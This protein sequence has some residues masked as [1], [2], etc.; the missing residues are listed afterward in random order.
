MSV[1]GAPEANPRS[2]VRDFLAAPTPEITVVEALGSDPLARMRQEVQTGLSDPDRPWVPATYLY[3]HAGSELY[4]EITRNPE[5]YLT[6][7]EVGLLSRIAPS[8]PTRVGASQLVELGSGASAKTRIVLDAFHAGSLPLTYI[9]IDVSHEM[10][11]QVAAQLV[12]AYDGMRVLGV[13]AEFDEA[14][15]ILP[16]SEGRLFMFFGGTLGNFSPAQQEVFFERLR[17][18]MAP[19][20]HLLLGFDVRPH[21]GKPAAVI[22]AAYDDAQ[23]LMARFNT[24]LLVR[25]NRELAADFRLD[26]WEHRAVYNAAEHQIELILESMANQ[27]VHV[28]DVPIRFKA[29][30][31]ILT[32][33]SRK[34]DPGELLDWLAERGFIR[35][36]F[37]M[38]DEEYYGMLLLRRA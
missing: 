12:E 22:Q 2:A 19:G 7:K 29:G 34:F 38:D 25:L 20:N 6:R 13:S 36:E 15:S 35:E 26:R 5:Y 16:P 31:G 4:V 14:L 9:P 23:Q 18:A 27:A 8:L 30:E 10:L 33:I 21:A 32:A 28:G 1:K 37:W 11:R 24:N 17:K 3:D